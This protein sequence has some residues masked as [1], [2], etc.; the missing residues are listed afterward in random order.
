MNSNLKIKKTL[1][2]LIGYFI[3]SFNPLA[4]QDFIDE[5]ESPYGFMEFEGSLVYDHLKDYKYESYILDAN[6]ILPTRYNTVNEIKKTGIGAGLDFHSSLIYLVVHQ[7][8]HRF[9][10]ADDFGFGTYLTSYSRTVKNDSTK[11]TIYPIYPNTRGYSNP[12]K[13]GAIIF[14]IGIQAVYRINQNWDI[15]LKYHPVFLHFDFHIGGAMGSEYGL[16][17]RYKRLFIDYKI[18]PRN[19]F[20]PDSEYNQ[21]NLKYLIRAPASDKKNIYLSAYWGYRYTPS[22]FK[23]DKP[24]NTIWSLIKIGFGFL[25]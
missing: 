16:H 5:K 25:M 2:L 13:S 11:Q 1:Q 21:L 17:V 19:T 22:E 4:A 8:K 6:Q 24:P 9:R 12:K 7:N 23:Y 14:Y 3:F 18:T 15:G 10:I 20:M